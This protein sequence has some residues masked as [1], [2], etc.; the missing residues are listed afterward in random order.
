MF[1]GEKAKEGAFAIGTI[2]TRLRSRM[3]DLARVTTRKE[4]KKRGGVPG[5]SWVRGSCSP[6][7]GAETLSM[8]KTLRVRI[9]EK[10][11]EGNGRPKRGEGGGKGT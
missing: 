11:K 10:S 4:W 9:R 7:S 8:G 3:K 5:R 6:A 1:A 2:K